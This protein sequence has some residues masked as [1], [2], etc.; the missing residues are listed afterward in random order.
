MGSARS[1][2]GAIQRA[3]QPASEPT[4]MHPNEG[5]VKERGPALNPS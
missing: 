3:E 4:D 1:Y 5:R 2:D